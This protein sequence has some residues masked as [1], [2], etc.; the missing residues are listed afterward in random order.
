MKKLKLIAFGIVMMVAGSLQSQISVRLNIGMPPQ[1]G[2]ANYDDVRYYYLPDIEC[3]YDVPH[4]SFIYYSGNGWIHS[5]NLPYRYRNYDLYNGY[6]VV[7]N[8]YRGDTPYNHFRE[9]RIKYVRG[10]RGEEHRN[11]GERHDD[12]ERRDGR[13]DRD[14][15]D[16]YRGSRDDGRDS[17]DNYRGRE[18]ERGHD[19]GNNEDHGH[20]RDKE[21]KEGHDD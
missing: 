13:D 6:K 7:M 14:S 19:Q 8:D 21:H 15:R 5:R 12:R 10:Y 2:P 3:Y 11:I 9:H 4:S 18:K 1:W 17:R 16:N 20:G